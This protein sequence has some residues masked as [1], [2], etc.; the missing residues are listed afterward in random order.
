MR[1]VHAKYCIVLYIYRIVLL[2]N[3][4]CN[5]TSKAHLVCLPTVCRKLRLNERWWNPLTGSFPIMDLSHVFSSNIVFIAYTSVR[6]VD[7]SQTTR[8]LAKCG[9]HINRPPSVNSGP[10]RVVAA[11]YPKTNTKRRER[12]LL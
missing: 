2:Q 11:F 1:V 9:R 10:V 8:G 3:I 4:K 5:C 7:N 6:L 12:L